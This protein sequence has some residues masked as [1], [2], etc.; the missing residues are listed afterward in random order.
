MLLS[1]TILFVS[2]IFY[3]YFGYPLLIQFLALFKKKNVDKAEIYPSVALVIAAYNEEAGIEKKIDESLQLNYP[4]DR[5]KIYIVSDASSDRTDEIVRQNESDRVK[6]LRIEGRVGKTEARN[7]A[8]KDI[9]EE[10]IVFSDATTEYHTDSIKQMVKNFADPKVGMV[11]GQLIYKIPVGS[12]M[13][14]GQRLFWRFENTIKTAQTK[15][16]TL[17]GSLG[18]MTAFRRNLYTDLPPNIIEDFTGP[19]M[20]IQK[21]YRVVYEQ[22]A[23]CF[24]DSTVKSS[25]EWKMRVRVI[26]GG[27]TG[28]SFAKGVLNPIMYPLACW[29]LVS[30]KILRWLVPVFAIA[31]LITSVLDLLINPLYSDFSFYLLS[32]QVLFYSLVTLG[33]LAE[34]MEVKIG[35]LRIFHYLFIVNLAAL[36][37]L[38]KFLTETLEATWEPDRKGQTA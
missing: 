10:I 1:I 26:R 6:L 37:A 9:H 22:T 21:G 16:G 23:K 2:L 27:M 19:L 13:G 30:H 32:A 38:Y 17:T 14:A 33:H 5:L 29:Q 12:T 15:L 7:L 28:L 24:E 35:P 20:I 34:K 3:T 4:E 36:A 18:C 31:A 11:T 8:L 25:Q